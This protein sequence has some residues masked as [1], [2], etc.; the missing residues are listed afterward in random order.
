[1][2]VYV[3][4]SI[5]CVLYKTLTIYTNI[6]NNPKVCHNNKQK[7]TIT[8]NLLYKMKRWPR[9]S[10]NHAHVTLG[11]FLGRAHVKHTGILNIFTTWNHI[12]TPTL[13]LTLTL[14]LSHA[15]EW[16]DTFESVILRLVAV[17]I[18]AMKMYVF[19]TMYRQ[20]WRKSWGGGGLV[21]E[22]YKLARPRGRRPLG[23]AKLRGRA[24]CSSAFATYTTRRALAEM[25]TPH[26]RLAN[27]YGYCVWMFGVFCVWINVIWNRRMEGYA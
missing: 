2:C 13:R 12:H 8:K 24:A 25:Y 11:F 21:W 7:T 18:I 20:K 1:M 5:I 17:I 6:L 10:H 16:P 23:A 14:Y 22:I 3:W 4:G 15:L 27:I 9:P 19:I 26:T